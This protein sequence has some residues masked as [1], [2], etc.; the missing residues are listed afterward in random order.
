MS[1]YTDVLERIGDRAPMPEPALER[2]VGRRERR[3]R[4]RR[5]SA[6]ALASIITAVLVLALVN[7]VPKADHEPVDSPSPTPIDGTA[8]VDLLPPAG[9]ELTT[10]G[11]GQLVFWYRGGVGAGTTQWLFL[12]TDGRLITNAGPYDE[13]LDARWSERRL[14]P[15]G[16]Q[17]MIS[18]VRALD[19][20]AGGRRIVTPG[21]TGWNQ[22][23][24]VPGFDEVVSWGPRL[25]VSDPDIVADPEASAAL[26][27][28]REQLL[29]PSSWLPS[30]AWQRSEP[31]RFAPPTYLVTMEPLD[32]GSASD[33]WLS[34]QRE[35][36]DL[37]L[38]TGIAMPS[39]RE[40]VTVDL[41]T[42]RSLASLLDDTGM[43]F[44][45]DA[46]IGL[47]SDPGAGMVWSALTGGR[48]VVITIAVPLPHEDCSLRPDR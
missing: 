6:G 35:L 30:S 28:L 10:G 37:P 24:A 19:L 42:A 21:A 39:V 36:D 32:E 47:D 25:W 3:R 22:S 18:A 40:C 23:S 27:H 12:Y 45:W 2:M 48:P 1:E 43:R 14:S 20:P 34:R 16:I 44:S 9:S 7:A 26:T 4:N 29:E 17:L 5:I 8:P 41:A 13:T 31:L 15:E 11:M 38:P 46:F 33:E